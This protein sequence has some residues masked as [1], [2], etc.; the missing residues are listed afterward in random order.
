[1]Y[2]PLKFAQ[3]NTYSGLIGIMKQIGMSTDEMTGDNCLALCNDPKF[4]TPAY[5]GPLE[6]LNRM[7]IMNR[8]INATFFG[9]KNP[10]AEWKDVISMY[11]VVD[12][13]SQSKQVYKFDRDFALELSKTEG[14]KL[15]PEMLRH[16]PFNTFY[17]DFD[18][19]P[20]FKPF[21]GIFVYVHVFDNDDIMI[22]GHRVVGE[23]YYTCTTQLRKD[24]R[25]YENG[26]AFYDYSRDRLAYTKNVPLSDF[27]KKKLGNQILPN[28]SF[29][30]IW[31]FLMQALTYLSSDQTDVEQSE[32][33][34]RT[35]RPSATR[36]RNNFREIREWEVGVRYGTEFRKRKAELSETNE[37]TGTGHHK[38]P[39]PHARCA[40]WHRY[41]TGKGRKIPKM[42]WV[43]QTFVGAKGEAPAVIH[44]VKG[45]SE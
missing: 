28:D 14:L 40:H 39:R 44:T 3:Q 6:S 29:P 19:I 43:A 41:W 16:L 26:V 38:S 25:E 12:K 42:K 18:G 30:M 33:T 20:E 10:R 36:I 32:L 11:G 21:D 37:E 13:W 5:K 4:Y 7:M 17:I 8:G 1:M 2:L 34:K 31:M 35:Y 27:L 9:D 22:C 23:I 45:E 15:Y 24:Q